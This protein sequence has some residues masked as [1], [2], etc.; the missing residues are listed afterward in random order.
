M[1]IK[2][3]KKREYLSN[4]LSVLN[5]GSTKSGDRNCFLDQPFYLKSKTLLCEILKEK[6]A[7]G[8]CSLID[9]ML[10]ALVYERFGRRKIPEFIPKIS[11]GCML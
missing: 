8:D 7:C 10:P 4:T 2:K 9:E 5:K 3:K 1:N 11:A 6:H